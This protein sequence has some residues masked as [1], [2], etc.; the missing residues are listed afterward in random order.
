MSISYNLIIYT[1]YY[2]AKKDKNVSWKVNNSQ[3]IKIKSFVNFK[4]RIIMEIRFAMAV[5]PYWTE[6]I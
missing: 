1:V 3:L 4:S 2:T 5:K 6:A